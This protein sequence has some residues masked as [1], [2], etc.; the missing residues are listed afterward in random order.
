MP[1]EPDQLHRL[2]KFTRARW[3][4]PSCQLCAANEWAVD[5]IVAITVE[6]R[7][8]SFEAVMG[9]A[10]QTLPCAAF[11]CRNCGNTVL[12]NLI[13]AGLMPQ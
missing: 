4:S 2:L 11:T 5:G 12:V 1:L 13:I 10:K 6:H 9:A 8:N 7:P 3:K